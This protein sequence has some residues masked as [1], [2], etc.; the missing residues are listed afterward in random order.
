MIHEWL[1]DP[2][3]GVPSGFAVGAYGWLAENPLAVQ[4]QGFKDNKDF[5]DI[6]D[7][8]CESLTCAAF[9]GLPHVSHMSDA[10]HYFRLPLVSLPIMNWA[11]A[12]QS[13]KGRTSQRR[14]CTQAQSLGNCSPKD[15]YPCFHGKQINARNAER[16]LF[17]HKC[18][19][20]L[21]S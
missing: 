10:S 18:G 13:H 7:A 16:E 19:A 20:N 21:M 2:A 8:L 14:I 9:L 17:V 15:S 4:A 3:G 12:P 1:I 6:K 5:N 11:A